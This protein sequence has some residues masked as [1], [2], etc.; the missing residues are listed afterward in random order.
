M[1]LKTKKLKKSDLLL[2]VLLI[3][4]ILAVLNFFSYRIFTRLDL[5]ENKSYSISKVSKETVRSLDDVV[6]IKLYFSKDLPTQFITLRQEV[7]DILDE[8]QAYSQGNIFIDYIFPDSDDKTAKELYA[9]GIPQLTF[10]VFEKDKSQVVKGYMAMT[11]GYG[12]NIEIIPVIKEDT[13]NLEYQITSAIK[14]VTSE[15]IATVAFLTSHGTADLQSQI[16]NAYQALAELYTVEVVDLNEENAIS[17][18]ID[19]LIIVGP[20]EQFTEEQLMEIN[21]FLM[22]GG[23]LLALVDGVVVEQGL[24]ARVNSTGL[25]GLISKY[26]V[27]INNNLVADVRNAM[28]SF[29]QGFFTFQTNYPF[30]LKIASDGFNHDHSAVSNLENVILQ[31]ASSLEFDEKDSAIT[32]LAFT[33]ERAWQVQDEFNLDPNGMTAKAGSEQFTVAAAINGE[34][35]NAYPQEG[36][37]DKFLGKLI[38]VGDSDFIN[39]NGNPDN[40][41]LFQNLVDSLSL[42]DD[43]INIRSKSVTS[44]PIQEELSDGVRAFIRYGNIFGITV[45]VIIFGMTRYY[46]RRKSRFL[47]EL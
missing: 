36:E 8:Y 12:D 43:L 26:G 32:P 28:A 46:L 35:E 15:E 31:W 40:L 29:S 21:S 41:T 10:Q 1:N 42:D 4:G 9:K 25:E 27:N 13:S 47:D 39:N 30:W 3:V 7:N 19:T 38:I 24:M 22:R 37:S 20:K 6:N 45:I 33:T 16:S 14:K 34:I 5:T 23:K 2:T 18:T 44:R 11:I 17:P